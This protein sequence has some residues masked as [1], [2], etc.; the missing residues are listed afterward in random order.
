[1]PKLLLPL[2]C[3][4]CL[5]SHPVSSQVAPLPPRVVT[6]DSG[7]VARRFYRCMDSTTYRQV[8]QQVAQL[9]GLRQ[10]VQLLEYDRGLLQQSVAQ[11]RAAG[12]QAGRDFGALA[13]DTRA[14]AAQPLARPLL[15]DPHTYQGAGAGVLA[16]LALKLFLHL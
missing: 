14:L 1:M 9:P 12:Q 6:L 13:A 4:S 10:R 5:L 11:Q 16:L 2:L 8:R 15:L 3:L 7:T